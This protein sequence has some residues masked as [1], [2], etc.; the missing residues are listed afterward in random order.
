MNVCV[1]LILIPGMMISLHKKPPGFVSLPSL[2]LLKP[3]II[4]YCKTGTCNN[5]LQIHYFECLNISVYFTM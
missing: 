3:H 5:I 4:I 2:E 1:Y